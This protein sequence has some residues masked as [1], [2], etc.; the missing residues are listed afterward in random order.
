MGFNL[1]KM[2]GTNSGLGGK[3]LSVL[4]PGL[5]ETA[6]ALGLGPK[7]GTPELM[8]AEM[9]ADA[10]KI[11]SDRD[12]NANLP[13][14]V[15]QK[16]IVNE[17]N[18]GTDSGGLLLSGGGMDSPFSDAL[19]KRQHKQFDSHT[20]NMKRSDASDAPAIRAGRIASSLG[21]IRNDALN[22]VKFAEKMKVAQQNKQFARN[23]AIATIF[24]SVGTVAGTA[25]G[26]ILGG[27]EGA[28][29]GATAGQAG[30]AA[31]GN[32]YTG[33]KTGNLNYL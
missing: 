18:R 11:L 2:L 3:A 20:S 9:N 21:A 7:V 32:E 26:G 15:Y 13:S 28:K 29:L 33:G 4:A 8:R 6:G 22:S 1:S 14:D 30:G 25:L 16:E 24:R 23:N 19:D 31:I 10:A 17:Q 5:Q 27:T 12:I